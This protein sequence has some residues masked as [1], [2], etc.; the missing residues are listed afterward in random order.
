[1]KIYGPYK[2]KDGRLRVV[3]VDGKIKTTVSYPKFLMEQHLGISLASEQDVHHIDGNFNNNDI[4][5]LEIIDHKEHCREHQLK[6]RENIT[7]HCVYCGK[8]K[9]LTPRQ[10][11]DRSGSKNRGKAGP[12]CNK[13]CSGKYGIDLQ[14]KRKE[15]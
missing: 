8:E 12:F 7:V 13:T 10:Q 3:L 11:R 15:V 4:S 5:N 6:Y 9:T 2:A 14:R 1:M